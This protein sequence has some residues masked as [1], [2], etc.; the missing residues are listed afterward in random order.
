MA[1]DI[2]PKPAE[3]MN[4]QAAA[5]TRWATNVDHYESMLAPVG[6][7]LLDL[8]AFAPGERVVEIGCG[9]GKLTRL[10]GEQ[11]VPGGSVLGLDISPDLTTLATKRAEAAGL[12]AVTFA[13]GDAQTVI[14]DEAPFDR[15]VSRFGV[16]FFEDPA[17]AMTNL[18]AMLAPAG[19]LDFAVWA[20]ADENPQ[21]TIMGMAARNHFNLA[22]PAPRS[23]GPLAFSETAY[24]ESLLRQA[25]FGMISF[26]K[27]TGEL[28]FGWAGMTAE[29]GADKLLQTGSLADMAVDAAP[30]VIAAARADMAAMLTAYLR[31]EGL[32][33][34]ASVHLV[35][36]M[37]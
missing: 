32:R 1:T 15:L 25:G 12:D 11:V 8:C 4:W 34:P 35:T 36:A 14:P 18:R 5:G 31:P 19:R 9:G 10:I 23:A 16:M 3:P 22:P 24:L 30:A 17:A 27:W 29:D 6:R 13:A 26:T 7:A 37:P 28:P 33:M 21:F 20:P 2:M